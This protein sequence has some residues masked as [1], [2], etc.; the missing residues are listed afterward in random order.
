MRMHCGSHD[1]NPVIS[2]IDIVKF[3]PIE[4]IDELELGFTLQSIDRII[5][6]FATVFFRRPVDKGWTGR[7][8]Q[9]N[10]KKRPRL[11]RPL[12]NVN[13]GD[14]SEDQFHKKKF[15]DA[16][17]SKRV[18]DLR[19]G[20]IGHSEIGVP[21]MPNTLPVTVHPIGDV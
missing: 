21:Q 4:I 7:T 9:D 18:I 15:L 11:I 10:S 2:Q 8:G 12:F 19:P 5:P 14:F 3:I 6:I 1:F 16:V 13:L 20:R 17:K